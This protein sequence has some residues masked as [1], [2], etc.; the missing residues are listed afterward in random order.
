MEEDAI[1]HETCETIELYFASNLAEYNASA[2][3]LITDSPSVMRKLRQQF[4]D[5]SQGCFCHCLHNALKQAQL[6]E[7]LCILSHFAAVKE[8]LTKLCSLVNSIRSSSARMHS[9][10][11]GCIKAELPK[12]KPITDIE[13]R[14]GYRCVCSYQCQVPK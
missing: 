9:F 2:F 5:L 7:C 10:E 14:W 11:Q 6:C 3:G 12:R 4:Q 13:W 1:P 8:A